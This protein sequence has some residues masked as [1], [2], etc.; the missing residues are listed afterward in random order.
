MVSLR[1]QRSDGSLSKTR[2]IYQCGAAS[3]TDWEQLRE[4]RQ[5]REVWLWLSRP[6]SPFLGKPCVPS[7]TDAFFYRVHSHRCP[8]Q[9]GCDDPRR[10]P[11]LAAG[12]L[13]G[14]PRRAVA[15]HRVRFSC[16]LASCPPVCDAQ[17]A[18]S[19]ATP[20]HVRLLRDSLGM[21]PTS[22]G[23]PTSVHG[24]R[25][26]SRRPRVQNLTGLLEDAS[27]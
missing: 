6:A 5:L 14:P 13:S 16:S 22:P 24:S 12:F 3:D 25:P 4:W 15:Q 17:P 20:T 19:R 2:S 8:S 11:R 23:H 10:H 7:G 21:L 27:L 1:Y 26:A 18:S 9:R